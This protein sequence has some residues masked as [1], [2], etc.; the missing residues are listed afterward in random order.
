MLLRL[1][2]TSIE[3]DEIG[4]EIGVLMGVGLLIGVGFGVDGV[5]LIGAKPA[6]IVIRNWTGIASIVKD[7]T[8]G[9]GGS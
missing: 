1:G 5:A 4:V 9:R 6:G 3:G 8:V 2:S 7:E